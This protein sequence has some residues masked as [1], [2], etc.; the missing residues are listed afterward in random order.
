MVTEA[1]LPL[2]S[3]L[4]MVLV[5]C[6]AMLGLL[7]PV[8]DEAPVVD[9]EPVASEPVAAE[10][11][12]ASLRLGPVPRGSELF[13][14]GLQEGDVLTH[15]S[16]TWREGVRHFDVSLVRDGRALRLRYRRLDPNASERCQKDRV[17]PVDLLR[18]REPRTI[19]V[20]LPSCGAR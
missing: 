8:S 2:P 1:K 10:P 17:L 6:A 4:G 15:V 13:E 19:E 20:V 11:N 3:I 7:W 12:A 14:M 18:N 9:A 16:S 5:A